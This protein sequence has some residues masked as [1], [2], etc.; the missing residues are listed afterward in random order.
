MT[1]P[2]SHLQESQKLTADG[3]VDLYEITLKTKPVIVRVKND[4]TVV[5]QGATWEGWP[6]LLQ[7][8][9]R[10]ADSEEARPTLRIH[11]PLGLFNPYARDGDLE[12]A[13]VVRKRVLREHI[14]SD[15][16]FYQQRMWFVARVREVTAGQ[17][18]TL[19]L[20]SFHDGPLFLL[21]GRLYIPP[22]FPVVNLS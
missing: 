18:V 17:A 11:N 5:W 3:L 10:S 9:K 2:V 7:G 16:N 19:E 4:D 13:T 15:T 21:P 8:D 1:I 12:Y 20:R 22:E 6:V 14:D